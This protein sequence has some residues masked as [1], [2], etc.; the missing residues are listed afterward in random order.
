MIYMNVYMYV[1]IYVWLIRYWYIIHYSYTY[2]YTI[3]TQYTNLRIVFRTR[4]HIVEHLRFGPYAYP[5]YI[6]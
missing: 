3:Y 1:C 6:V 5:I 4:W 2:T